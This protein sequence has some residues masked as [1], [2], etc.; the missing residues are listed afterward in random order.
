MKAVDPRRRPSIDLEE[1]TLAIV[2][3]QVDDRPL[4]TTVQALSYVI[5]RKVLRLP[6]RQAKQRISKDHREPPDRVSYIYPS[7]ELIYRG[8]S[9]MA[10]SM[11]EQDLIGLLKLYVRAVDRGDARIM[12]R[13]QEDPDRGVE[14]AA[15]MVYI[16]CREGKLPIPSHTSRSCETVPVRP[17]QVQ[18][19]SESPVLHDEM[20]KLKA[21]AAVVP[22]APA[23]IVPYKKWGL[24]EGLGYLIMTDI[25]HMS[26]NQMRTIIPCQT[27]ITS[28]LHRHMY[29]ELEVEYENKVLR[30]PRLAHYAIK[31]MLHDFVTHH[32]ENV[33]RIKTCFD[34]SKKSG[35]QRA[36]SMIYVEVHI[37]REQAN[38]QR[39]T[40]ES[41]DI[42]PHPDIDAQPR[43]SLSPS[44]PR[45]RPREGDR[46]SGNRTITARS[47]YNEPKSYVRIF[48]VWNL[49]DIINYTVLRSTLN[50]SKHRIA[51]ALNT[52]MRDIEKLM[53]DPSE[54]MTNSMW[55]PIKMNYNEKDITS[56]HMC[57]QDIRPLVH[58]F[59]KGPHA[60]DLIKAC[61]DKY[62]EGCAQA[63]TMIYCETFPSIKHL[64]SPVPQ[65]QPPTVDQTQEDVPIGD[66]GPLFI[67]DFDALDNDD[68][69]KRRFLAS[70]IEQPTA[71]E[72]TKRRVKTWSAL[73]N[74]Q[75]AARREPA[76]NLA[77]LTLVA[78]RKASDRAPEGSTTFVSTDSAPVANS[79]PHTLYPQVELEMM[80][81]LPE[82]PTAPSDPR[83]SPP[84]GNERD[85]LDEDIALPSIPCIAADSVATQSTGE[86]QACNASAIEPE[87]SIK[88]AI[89]KTPEFVLTDSES[90][91]D[92]D[93]DETTPSGLDGSGS[94]MDDGSSASDSDPGKKENPVRHRFPTIETDP[95]LDPVP[96]SGGSWP[97]I[98]GT[99]GTGTGEYLA[100]QQF[101]A[102]SRIFAIRD[103]TRHVPLVEK[104]LRLKAWGG[105][106]SGAGGRGYCDV[107]LQ[108]I[109]AARAQGRGRVA[110]LGVSVLDAY[111]DALREDD[112]RV[113]GLEVL[114]D[115]DSGTGAPA[116]TERYLS[117]LA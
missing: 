91:N 95:V 31:S 10:D 89:T 87:R 47:G 117:L 65:N 43:N 96:L 16:Q 98:S 57:F 109:E 51:K 32:P 99:T 97:S 42:Q 55:P 104:Y 111:L 4:W 103:R 100:G 92:G 8:R 71:V 26:G 9:M 38:R 49:L 102:L 101:M 93:S 83:A 56:V 19:E 27:G 81:R 50:V 67:P 54:S 40:H 61:Y 112:G 78:P 66:S 5:L 15:A 116:L 36:A 2:A 74:L 1:P 90:E 68:S 44:N 23:A 17:R 64:L 70:S 30:T 33:D 76:P 60:L 86:A 59:T 13:I 107:L 85:S 37:L 7:K 63:A 72:A 77:H 20:A 35:Y 34:G 115:L 84:E 41:R 88:H 46:S 75:K 53:Y 14:T 24:L 58:H 48:E 79:V 52:R 11:N 29:P 73:N 18:L 25:L 108:G 105:R 39:L 113:D 45:K 28:T 82:S 12:N 21:Q 110:S 106:A 62:G 6:S 94:R 69:R 80:P 114:M 3:N 22:R